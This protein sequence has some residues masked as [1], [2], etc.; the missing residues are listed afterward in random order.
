MK[1]PGRSLLPFA[2]RLA[3]RWP[4][5]PHPGHRRVPG[6]MVFA[7]ISGF[8]RLTERLARRGRVGAELMSDTLDQTFAALLSPAFAEGADLLKWGGDAVLLLFRAD[9]D[10]ADGGGAYGDGVD[11]GAGDAD[12]RDD[13]HALRAVRAAH[14]MRASLR[15]L[16]R[17]RA[18]PVPAVL[19]MSIGVHSSGVHSSD[20]GRVA[21]PAGGGFDFFMVGDEASHRELIVAGPESSRLTA[22]EQ[23]CGAGQILL[24]AAT[25]ARLPAACLGAGIDVRGSRARLLASLPSRSTTSSAGPPTPGLPAP[26]RPGPR[27][28]YDVAG[29]HSA[30][31]A[32]SSSSVTETLPPGIRAHLLAGVAAPEH[33]AITVAFVQFSGTDRLL[34][35]QGEDA[36]TRAVH[37]LVTVVQQACL[38]H[39]VTFFES[40]IADDGG[41]IMLTAGAPRSGRDDAERMLRAAGEIAAAPGPLGVR[42]GVNLGHV[43][44]GE[45]GHA[46][47]RTYSIKGDAVNLAARL[48]THAD[49]GQV[50]ATARVVDAVHADVR[51]TALEPFLVKGKRDPVHA[52]VVHEVGEPWSASRD[53]TPFVGRDA[54]QAA[55]HARLAASA[56]GE[57]CVIDVVGDPGIG[58]SRL[59][60]ELTIPDGMRRLVVTVSAYETVTPYA[61]I[62]ILL[63]AVLGI[64]PHAASA[65]QADRLAAGVHAA[66]P[67]L[68]PWLP[69]LGVPLGLAL[70]STREVDELEA[71]F[72]R[73]RIEQVT[74][75]LLAALLAEPVV[76][77][78]ED[79]HLMDESS[80]SLLRRLADEARHR[81]WCV[82]VT[83]REIPVGFVPQLAQ[84]DERIALG[85]IAPEDALELLESA[86][87]SA[88]P[89]RHT[90]AAM[91]ERARGNP[92]FLTSLATSVHSSDGPDDLPESVEA[93]LQ[94]DIDRLAPA[95]KA[96]LR[97]GAVLGTRFESG[98]LARLH[99][100]V[101]AEEIAGRLDEF[102]R[103]VEGADAGDDLEFRHTM[104]RD[105]AYAGLPYRLRRELHERVALALEAGAGGDADSDEGPAA[106]ADL[107]SL[108]FHAAGLYDKAWSAS[109]R[110][111]AEA[112]AKYAYGQAAVFFDRALDSAV[113]LPDV[114]AGDRVDAR[115][116]LGECLDMAGDANGALVA[117]R[118]ARREMGADP[119]AVAEGLYKEARIT[120][121]LGRYRPTLAQ[122]TRA[123]RL[124]DGVDGAAA[125]TVRARLATRYGFCLHLQHRAAEAVRWGRRGV[126][127]AEAAG[128]TEVLAHAFNALHLAYGAS[129]LDE[130][131]PYGHLALALYEQLGDLSGQAL[132]LNNLAIDAYNAGSWGQAID[133]FTRAAESFHRLGDDANEATAVYNRGD[134]LVA[135]RRH[136]EALP[137]LR[138]ALGLARHVDDEE[139]VGL[140]LREQARA[141]A[142]VGDTAR[143]WASFAQ[144]RTVLA[145]LELSTEVALLDAAYA[146]AL[147]RT[148]QTDRALVVID[149]AILAALA[150]A[151]DTL[152]RLHRIRAQTLVTR[153]DDEQA[154]AAARQG[155][156]YT[157]GDFGGYEP[158]L[159]RLALAQ[160]TRD[161]VL[162]AQAESALVSLGVVA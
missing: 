15:E 38:R 49:A 126:A 8:T 67:D 6:T 106:A 97:L 140:V 122:L 118:R 63:R 90:L 64:A 40:D 51:R 95:D 117:L 29:P 30:D 112:R 135:Q 143:A 109:L 74:V 131:R 96:L 141:E 152:A 1:T 5:G 88:R 53:R 50:V 146:E 71:R 113:H 43:F 69:L 21:G 13:D 159:L 155:L 130:D 57:G 156:E 119:V 108:H 61:A 114:A 86:T 12:V 70:P 92:L 153:G 158:A 151:S 44:S 154:A 11:D 137:V 65:D 139:L 100:G 10:A 83:R 132:T 116:S 22:V 93:L 142:G 19:R 16:V 34:A 27:H 28:P 104:V 85:A 125:D 94:V 84:G 54:E 138:I 17:T 47:R 149:D 136:A 157:A 66:A 107:L 79:T 23:A 41:K 127:W 80:G 120:L 115:V 129:A 39:G 2:P 46:L 26:A 3:T 56:A 24:S 99:S 162:R 123:L 62:G 87:G 76:F 48:L 91:A 78:F 33:R 59:V 161:P 110:A 121:R 35:E 25:A 9:G 55:L 36:A 31:H 98:L 81:S 147:A 14:R 20:A 144:A 42:V 101:R 7:D 72:R 103:P 60:G 134:V 18:L 102:V 111:G 32:A 150:K 124:L 77:V 58:K 160:A 45:L 4:P 105:V 148:G 145:G 89:S 133:D 37:T 75:A 82:L 68:A 128:E 52:V 73:A